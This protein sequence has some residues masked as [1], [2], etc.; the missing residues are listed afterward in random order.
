MQLHLKLHRLQVSRLL[1][2]FSSPPP[3]SFSAWQPTARR[4]VPH[5][6]SSPATSQVR[7]SRKWWVRKLTYR[8]T[9][10]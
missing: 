8:S 3:L 6:L 2:A 7:C 1:A 5:S 4:C 10:P 9:T